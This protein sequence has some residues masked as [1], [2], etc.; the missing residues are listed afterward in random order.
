M[1][2]EEDGE[3]VRGPHIKDSLSQPQRDFLAVGDFLVF[4]LSKEVP[5]RREAVTEQGNLTCSLMLW[6]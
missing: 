4:C 3:L 1:R 2:V 6:I 5:I